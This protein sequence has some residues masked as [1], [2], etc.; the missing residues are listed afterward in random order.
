LEIRTAK[1][2]R[3][4]GKICFL[5][6]MLLL[7]YLMFFFEAYG[8]TIAD[9]KY[10]YNFIP[11]KEIRR[12][13]VYRETLGISVMITNII[14]NVAGFV[15]FGFILPLIYKNK[16]KWWLI[17]F[18]TME[19]SMVIELLQLLLKVGSCDVDDVILNTLGGFLG[20]VLFY[21]CNRIR[22]RLDG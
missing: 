14:G 2:I 7:V 13:I 4:A 12:F 20:Y 10:L 16:R 21:I 17:T 22:R 5:L 3:W 18:L 15:P 11:F 9:R 8:R 6:Y 1:K 19:F